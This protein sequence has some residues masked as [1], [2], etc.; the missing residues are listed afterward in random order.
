MKWL[1]A[2]C[3][4]LAIAVG[5]GSVAL[6]ANR[7]EAP[8]VPIQGGAYHPVRLALGGTYFVEATYWQTGSGVD[9]FYACGDFQTCIVRNFQ[10][11]STA[12]DGHL[13]FAARCR[14]NYVFSDRGVTYLV[15]NDSR[16]G[17]GDI[18]LY[19][20]TDL[21]HWAIQN[22][23][24]PIAARRPG[25]N[26]A[27]IWNVAI[28]PV[29]NRWFML[30]ETS[31]TLD[32]MNLSISWADPAV[33]MD[34]TGDEGPTVIQNAGNPQLLYQSGELVALHGKY[35]TVNGKSGNWYVTM[36]TALPSRPT[37]WS[38]RPDRLRIAERGIDVADPTYMERNGVGRLAVSYDQKEV[39]ELVGPPIAP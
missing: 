10:R 2:L 36:S 32:G 14:F 21:V 13:V 19:A 34:F 26:W 27:H 7:A 8:P 39:V 30:A 9:L 18:Y 35:E 29:G 25:T 12:A 31:D 38:M 3:F 24:H 6:R 4:G 23:G 37:V 1:A 28:Q 20:S 33:S 22:D 5:A 15:C 11:R 16:P 17:D